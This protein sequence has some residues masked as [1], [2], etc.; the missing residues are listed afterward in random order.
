MKSYYEEIQRVHG[1]RDSWQR[2]NGGVCRWAGG[3]K[4]RSLA[5]GYL[6]DFVVD[7]GVNASVLIA[8][9]G[10]MCPAFGVLAPA[11]KRM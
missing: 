2:I 5:H 6:Y 11:V 9:S 8:V 1:R 3:S 7:R 10:N 4:E